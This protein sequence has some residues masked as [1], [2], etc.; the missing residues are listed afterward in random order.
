MVHAEG[1]EEIYEGPTA[2]GVQFGSSLHVWVK[3]VKL[4]VFEQRLSHVNP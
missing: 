3:V 4:A 2:A 1:D